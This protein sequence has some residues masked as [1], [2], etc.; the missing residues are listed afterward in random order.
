MYKILFGAVVCLMLCSCVSV[1]VSTG[2]YGSKSP[3]TGSAGGA[4]T[5][6]ANSGLEKCSATLGTLSIYEDRHSDWYYQMGQ[7]GFRTLV[8]VLRL[9]AQQSGCFV[10]VERGVALDSAME[11]R[12]FQDS[13]ELRK[14]SNFGKGQMVSADYT[15]KPS[16]IFSDNNSGGVGSALGG[17]FGEVGAAIGGSLNF[18]TAQSMITLVDNRSTVQVAVAEGSSRGMDIG[19]IGELFGSSAGGSL[20]AYTRTA[21]G[22]VI[23]GALMDAHNNMVIAV[24]NY[25][26]QEAAGPG[27][28]GTGGKLTVTGSTPAVSNVDLGP[29]KTTIMEMQNILNKLGFN[30]GPADGVPGEK[31]RQSIKT[32]QNISGLQPTGNLDPSTIAKLRERASG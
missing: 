32:F 18:K 19:G 2:S 21:E 20:G 11:E 30:V 27:G 10:V 15:V 23:V 25:R 31:T 14:G 13:G 16:L 7:Q 22:K 17:V 12:E 9:F 28:H 4:N 1:P 8:P 6:G 5:V 24:R 26:P 3:A 29:D